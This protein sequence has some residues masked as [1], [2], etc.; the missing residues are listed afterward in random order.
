MAN[1]ISRALFHAPAKRKV[2]VQLPDEDKGKDEGQMCGRLNNPMY[3]TRDAAQNWFDAYS[4][5]LKPIGFQ[6]G[7]ASPCTLHH[8]Q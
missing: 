7:V 5:Q 8:P 1:D 2:Y 3:G 6:Q 4:Q